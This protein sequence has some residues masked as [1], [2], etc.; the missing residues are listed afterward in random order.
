MNGWLGTKP[1]LGSSSGGAPRTSNSRPGSVKYVAT[2][3]SSPA[4][5]VH[6]R[7]AAWKRSM[8]SIADARVSEPKPAREGVAV[9]EDLDDDARVGV[10]E[11]GSSQAV[12]RDGLREGVDPGSGED[13]HGAVEVADGHAE[14]DPA[15]VARAPVGEQRLLLRPADR[16]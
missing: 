2:A 4:S 9:L 16:V 6:S 3:F 15:V 8:R 14:P 5:I 7:P 13:G 10:A 11:G 12:A 1:I